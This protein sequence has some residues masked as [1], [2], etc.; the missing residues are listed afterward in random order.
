MKGEFVYLCLQS[1][2]IHRKMKNHLKSF[3]LLAKNNKAIRRPFLLKK[4]NSLFSP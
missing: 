4:F 2:I 3:L 1:C